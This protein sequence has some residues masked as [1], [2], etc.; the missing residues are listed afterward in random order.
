MLISIIICTYRRTAAVAALLE[1]LPSQTHR[2]FEVLLVDGSGKGSAEAAELRSLTLAYQ[3][4]MNVKVLS[5][6]KGLTRQRNL[7]LAHARGELI[8]FLD[9]DVTFGEDFLTRTA[10]LFAA[11]GAQNLGG[12][13]AYDLRNYPQR[14][15]LRW[16]I[17]RALHLVPSLDPGDIDRLG[18]S[19]P[20]SFMQPF[21]GCKRVGYL[22]GFSMIYRREAI[23][24][25]RFDEALPTYGGE[26]RDF[27]SRVA[28][29]W[30]LILCGDLHLEHHCAPQSRDSGVERTYQA[31]FG[32]GRGFGKNAVRASDY[33]ELL[34]LMLCEFA[35]DSIACIQNPSLDSA[36]MIF[37]RTRGLVAG[38]QSCR[39][40][41]YSIP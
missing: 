24:D 37:A 7:G 8:C 36:R 3:G 20:V 14:I 16:R 22:Y 32:I 1:C 39:R 18:R 23:G 2:D 25:L 41:S 30:Q 31:G 21:T 11:P 27:S 13:S 10:Q 26:D 40:R 35:V 9:D 19:V 28:R 5:S 12:A 34:R 4:H 38:V 6:P 33:L 29:T 15:N 17:R